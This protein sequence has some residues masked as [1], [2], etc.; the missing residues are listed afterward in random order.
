MFGLITVSSAKN[1]ASALLEVSGT[2]LKE[3]LGKINA[4]AVALENEA[5]TIAKAAEKDE[6]TSQVEYKKAIADAQ[7]KLDAAAKS[8]ADRRQDAAEKTAK[9]ASKKKTVNMLA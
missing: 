4:Q 5:I 2:T 6:V 7:A 8:V 1:I 9:A 3:A